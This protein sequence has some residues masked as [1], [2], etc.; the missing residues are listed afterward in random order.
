M[1]NTLPVLIFAL[2]VVKN[3]VNI[4]LFQLVELNKQ[5]HGF[6]HTKA[7]QGM[8]LAYQLQSYTQQPNKIVRGFLECAT[9]G[10]E[11]CGVNKVS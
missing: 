3:V 1:T 9:A 6:V 2:V 5:Y 7:L 8:R 11:P 4:T 10:D